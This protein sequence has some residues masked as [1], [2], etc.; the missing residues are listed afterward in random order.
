MRC[1]IVQE[2]QHINKTGVVFPSIVLSALLAAAQVSA[3]D[4]YVATNGVAP[5]DG[6]KW[7]WAYTNVQDALTAATNGDTIYLA[8]QTFYLTNQLVWAANTNVAIR[9]GFD[10]K[11]M[12][13]RLA[14]QAEEPP[15]QS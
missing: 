5:N 13:A 14:G 2:I 1:I 4:R 6:S 15:K 8:G 11:N 3:T 9:G 7:S 10:I 12:L